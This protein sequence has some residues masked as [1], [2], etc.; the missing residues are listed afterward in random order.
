V[1]GAVTTLLARTSLLQPSHLDHVEG[2]LAVL[3]H[4]MNEVADK[5]S[6]IDDQEKQTRINELYDLVQ[7]C[8]G[9]GGALPDIVDR[10][11]TLQGLHQQGKW[12]EYIGNNSSEYNILQ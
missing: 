1:V 4:K 5:K 12:T 6:A 9:M 8:E 2:R 3:V 11:D 7:K 10:L